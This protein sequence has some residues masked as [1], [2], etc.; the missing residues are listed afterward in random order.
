MCKSSKMNTRCLD[1]C[2]AVLGETAGFQ[3]LT[4]KGSRLPTYHQVLLCYLANKEKYKLKYG[5]TAK[6]QRPVSKIVV[7]EVIVHYKKAHI[8][9]ISL[10]KMCEK[11]ESLVDD[12]RN[13]CKAYNYTMVEKF[14][15]KLNQ[16]MP[17]W[18]RD[19]L[20]KMEAKL[21]SFGTSDV[22]ETMIKEDLL[23]L[24][25]MMDDRIAQYSSKDKVNNPRI[26]K[27]TLRK[28]KE[29]SKNSASTSGIQN[30][31]L[32]ISDNE[33]IVNK[34]D[35]DEDF[36]PPTS[37]RHNRKIKI[38]GNLSLGPNFVSSPKVSSA[39]IRN[40]VT[41]TKISNVM[42]TVIKEAGLD[43]KSFNLSYSHLNNNRTKSAALTAYKIRQYSTPP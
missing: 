30:V 25:S 28:A 19:L 20:T 41:S 9:N 6:I 27:S 24:K 32:Q 3:H 42:A 16:T 1:K 8:A 21:N 22:E 13:V 17:F 5:M 2:K 38:G 37:L 11:V 18:P 34:S 39:C 4:I 35:S 23:F 26:A 7:N 12:Y 33:E 31:E 40:K 36:C 29:Q 10:T 15:K 14:K 43:V